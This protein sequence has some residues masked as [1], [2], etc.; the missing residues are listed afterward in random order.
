MLCQYI[1]KHYPECF[2]EFIC[3][4]D[5]YCHQNLHGEIENAIS[6]GLHIRSLP[7]I[8]QPDYGDDSDDFEY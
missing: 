6:N 7:Y 2:R 5:D 1:G 8:E 4:R 3:I